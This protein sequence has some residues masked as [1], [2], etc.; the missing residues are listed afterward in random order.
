VPS[1]SV[2]ETL[3]RIEP[4]LAAVPMHLI[5]HGVDSDAPPLAFP[6]REAGERLRL[7]VLGRLSLHKGMQ[8][9]REA[10]PGLAPH[11]EVTIVGG[12]GNGVELAKAC[13]WRSIEKYTL[14][15]LPELLAGIAPHA[16][17][18]ASIVPETFSYTLSELWA[19]CVPPLAT[20]L[21]SFSE[22]ISDGEDGF[23]FA[24]QASALVA[25]VERLRGDPAALQAVARNLASHS[26]G[27][28]VADMVAAY[29]ALLPLAA[30]PAA[31]FTVGIGRDTALTEPYRHL[32]E[33]YAHLSDAYEQVRNAYASTQDAQR[34]TNAEYERALG[35]LE[36]MREISREEFDRL[37][38]L[39]FGRRWWR[40]GDAEK[41]LKAWRE[42]MPLGT[43]KKR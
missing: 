19:L 8:L 21:G 27:G 6:A 20:D 33:A 24:P 12:G 37:E 16:A 25:L 41:L 22:R 30:R 1:R 13:G 35:E 17:I 38:A 9:L 34:H 18:L 28:T 3:K 5:P 2:A 40:A 10:A 15:E 39:G 43:E 23:L 29:H 42:K 11:A 36:R 4:R 7:V 14:E 31:R 32:N 26:R